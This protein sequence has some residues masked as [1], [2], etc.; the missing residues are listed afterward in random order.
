MDSPSLPIRT[1]PATAVRWRRILL[2]LGL[3]FLGLAGLWSF[4]L[5]E[6]WTQRLPP[7]WKWEAKFVG[8]GTYPDERAGRFPEKDTLCTYDRVMR[9]AD[10]AGRPGSV[11]VEDRYTSRNIDT[12][13]TTWDYLYR[14]VIDPRTGEHLQPE[15]RGDLLVFPR[16]VE[17]KA[18]SLRFTY[19]KGLPLRFEREEPIEGLTTYLFSYKG[20]GEYT[21]SYE[22]SDQYPGVKV[23]PGQEIKCADDQFVL[24]LWVEPVTGEVVKVQ[25]DAPTGDWIYDTATGARLSPVMRWGGVTA[26]DDVLS[27]V[28]QVGRQRRWLIWV[29][30]CIPSFLLALGLA[31]LGGAAWA[32]TRPPSEVPG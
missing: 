11:I 12:G 17:K 2:A 26:G 23:K 20:R 15:Y 4:A 28:D 7:G 22:G 24:R 14:C 18:Y 10:E 5:A 32:R 1:G 13:E 16:G 6:H 19:I 21:E 29:K 3:L 27:R 8:Y 31:C 30:W 25:E 9:L